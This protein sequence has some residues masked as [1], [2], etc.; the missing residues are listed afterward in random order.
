MNWLFLYQMT[1]PKQ[2]DQHIWDYFFHRA[3]NFK[4]SDCGFC[5]R[6]EIGRHKNI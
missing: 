1:D 2:F 4:N 3:L 5:G 6:G